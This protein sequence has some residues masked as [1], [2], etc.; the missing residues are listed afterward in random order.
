ML[1]A[2]DIL[3]EITRNGYAPGTKL[4]PEREM[5][6]EYRVARATLREAL[7]FLEILGVLWIKPGPGGGPVVET[8]QPLQ[9]AGQLALLLHLTGA[10]FNTILEAREVLEPAMASLAAERATDAELA[11]IRGSVDRMRGRLKDEHAFLRE[12]EHFHAAV[13]DASGNELFKLLL[14][15]LPWVIDVKLLGVSYPLRYRKVV[16]A[17]H[18]AIEEAIASRDPQVAGE[19]MRSHMRDFRTFLEG[20]HKSVLSTP[21]RWEHW[22][23]LG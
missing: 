14:A 17:G 23:P 19:A 4:P 5:L 12:N 16:L 2:Q 15:S 11:A 18:I 20:S 8:P 10:Q 21:L 1:V 7:R 22:Q 3:G 6:E 13:S 9:L